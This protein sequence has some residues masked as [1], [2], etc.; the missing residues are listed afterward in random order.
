[1]A[2]LL[3]H[4]EYL[5]REIGPRPA[6]TEEEQQAALYIA[7]QLQQES[8]FH[9][10]I[11]EFTSSSNLEGARAIPAVVIILVTILAMLFNVLTIPALVLTLI[12]GAL[13]VLEAFD[14]PI[15]SRALS[16]GAS[17]NV[18]AKYQP[19]QS[20]EGA[21]RRAR[22]R[23]VVLVAHYD[24]GKVKPS[25]IK[26]IE[27]FGLP[28][29]LICIGAM[30]AT[31]LLLLVRVF[32][33]GI[34]GI[35]T[36]VLNVL[37]IIALIV[38]ALPVVK[39]V[40]YRMAPYNEGAN[41][42]ATGSAALIEI[43][44][45]IS[46]GSSSEADLAAAEREEITEIDDGVIMHGLEAA[47]ESGLVPEGV[48]ISYVDEAPSALAVAPAAPLQQEEPAP[49]VYD[50]YDAYDEYDEKDR[51]LAA[52]A[53]IAALT[54]RPVDQ[55]LYAE[56]PP[57]QNWVSGQEPAVYD[58]E[59]AEGVAPLYAESAG[60]EAAS[61]AAQGASAQLPTAVPAAASTVVGVQ[62]SMTG[63]RSG[64]SAEANA[65]EAAGFKNAPSWFVA[66]QKNAKKTSTDS[67]AVQRSRYTQAIETVEREAA[68]RERM[69][70]EEEKLKR[71][72]ATRSA[73]RA[74]QSANEQPLEAEPE[75]AEPL[76]EVSNIPNEPITEPDVVS[77]AL[78]S[79]PVPVAMVD[80]PSEPVDLGQ[81][82]ACKPI[83]LDEGELVVEDQ[84]EAQ[85][86][87]PLADLP[88]LE[89]KPEPE[90]QPEVESEPK[91]A[92]PVIQVPEISNPSRSGMF[93]KLRADV[94]SLSGVIRMQEAGLDVSQKPARPANVS[95]PEINVP[96]VVPE[97]AP[98]DYN[99]EVPVLDDSTIAIPP[100]DLTS[101]LSDK[102]NTVGAPSGDG[103]NDSASNQVEMPASRADGFLGRLRGKDEGLEESPQEWLDVDKDFDA[104]TVGRERGGWESFR[105]ESGTRTPDEGESRD[106]HGGAFSRVR[107]GHVNTRSVSG[108]ESATAEEVPPTDEDRIL[109]EEIGQII[110]FRNPQYNTEIWFVAIG[111]DTEL[112]DGARAFV[113]EHRSDL[114]GAMVIEVESLGAGALS[115]VSEEGQFR[116]TKASSRVKRYTRPATEA[117]GIALDEVKVCGSDSVASVIQ[118]EGF[119]TMHLTGVEDGAI[120][121][122]GSADDVC[123]N[124]DELTL[125]ENI[126][127]LMELL[128][129]N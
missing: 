52:K 87:N 105:D 25:I 57:S 8:G 96:A 37:T 127:F 66:A 20:E 46:Q 97:A 22:T 101:A 35:P 111:S 18:V 125:E 63:V 1:M 36:I 120:A 41:N 51:L 39:A 71:E 89:P 115:V 72:A 121:L 31:A 23:K 27:S 32:F 61:S 113:N 78:Q 17:Q 73:L 47:I 33:G 43:A 103:S 6:G 79:E 126:A 110:H 30:L 34:G 88:T 64:A 42:N 70:S 5:S 14:K 45:L 94:P 7:D 85:A 114:R 129:H 128:K 56:E 107:L 118:K 106:W 12:A 93:R 82:I 55:R 38:V 11:E 19:N 98:V 15:V 74:V 49:A 90:P 124:V 9:A 10:E 16:R 77:D 84:P 65:A 68:E 40:M 92:A 76:P 83:H 116:R 75:Q 102:P 26:R 123:E 99:M 81:T 2:Q 48:E 3:D 100:A 50:D 58:E 86:A 21:G 24:T 53:A 117:T 60:F 62:P 69:R 59:P 119:Q 112:H 80:E 67:S 109:N 44:R 54:G 13:Y 122:K 104:R 29:G 28:I 91:S 108:E 95:V 4:V